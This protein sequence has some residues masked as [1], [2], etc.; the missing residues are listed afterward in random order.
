MFGASY[1]ASTVGFLMFA[2]RLFVI[3]SAAKI[4]V[5]AFAVA[6]AHQV[7]KFRYSLINVKV[8]AVVTNSL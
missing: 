3:R 1:T 6:Q 4:P 8:F 7:T 2:C 5:C